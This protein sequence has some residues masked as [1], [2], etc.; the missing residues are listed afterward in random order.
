L[1]VRF[2]YPTNGQFFPASTTIGVQALVL[3]STAVKT[4]QYFANGTSI[5]IVTN[6][7]VSC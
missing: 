4:V 2:Y 3:D 1:S 7:A 6:T 5:G